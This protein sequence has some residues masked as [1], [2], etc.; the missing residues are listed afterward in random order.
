M[1]TTPYV[2]ALSLI[3]G[4]QFCGKNVD[5]SHEFGRQTTREATVYIK[6]IYRSR[7]VLC[8]GHPVDHYFFY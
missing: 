5:Y 3:F 7:L 6:T 8:Q 4:I 2:S 1:G